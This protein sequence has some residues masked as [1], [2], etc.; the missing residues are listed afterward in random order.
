MEA[1]TTRL[2]SPVWLALIIGLGLSIRLTGL[3]VGQGYCRGHP[4]D[5]VE[6][7]SWAVDFAR[8]EPKAQYLGQPNYNLHAKL[9]GPLWSLFCFTGLRCWGSIEGVILGIILVNTAAIYVC[10][11]LA[12]RTLGP[13]GSLWTALLA[14]TLPFPIFYS[15][16]VYNPNV[17]PFLGGLLFLALWDVI[18][19]D[20]ARSIFWVM[21][22]LLTMPQFHMCVTM[23]L[24]AV[25]LIL[26]LASVR[27]HLPCLIGGLFAGALLY[28]PYIRGEMAHGWQNTLGMMSAPGHNAWGGLKALAAPLS[29]LTNWVPQWTGSVAAYREL[30]RACFGSFAV[31][32]VLNLL[33]AIVA[34]LLLIRIF[35]RTRMALRGCLQTPR[36]VFKR[37]QELLFL[38]ILTVVP[39]LCA[40]A[41]GK[42]FRSHYAIVLFG[43]LLSLAGW[44]ASTFISGS[45]SGRWFR[46]ALVI[47]TCGNIWFMPAMF[48]YQSG[49]IDRGE[50]FV[51]S[52]RKSESIYQQLKAYAGSQ[53]PVIVDDQALAKELYGRD[54][55][56]SDAKLIGRYVATRE[57]ESAM[58]GGEKGPPMIFTLRRADQ[59]DAGAPEVAYRAHGI[60]L[61]AAPPAP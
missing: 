34:A 14:A 3:W 37:S 36:Q 13:S 49:R 33:S 43:P 24:P 60:A 11:R 32:L 55:A 48:R 30:G 15:I 45:G 18:Q 25:C 1:R 46:V 52:F 5:G 41:S 39:L 23:L 28:I 29:L 12:E 59:A 4:G 7:Y 61:V 56:L 54:D 31:F 17:M 27:I 35:Q 9:P 53:R 21:L 8:G 6:A 44:A 19:R 40:A 10:Y 26:L 57:V 58:L 51:F 16:S 2:H 47:L 42:N 20:R 22:L 38:V 50:V